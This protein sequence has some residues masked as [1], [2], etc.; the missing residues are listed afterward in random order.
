MQTSQIKAAFKTHFSRIPVILLLWRQ[1]PL[2]EGFKRKCRKRH[3]EP[4]FACRALIWLYF[5]QHCYN[6]W[7]YKR[8][9]VNNLDNSSVQKVRQFLTMLLVFSLFLIRGCRRAGEVS[10]WVVTENT[11]GTKC[12][13]I[14]INSDLCSF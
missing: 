3:S 5:M 6:F 7:S 9:M 8:K 2:R 1:Q 10:F 4:C 14:L 11:L 13:L 12:M